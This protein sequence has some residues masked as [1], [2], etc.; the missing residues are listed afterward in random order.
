MSGGPNT[1]TPIEVLREADPGF[2]AFK[3]RYQ[4]HS[5]KNRRWADIADAAVRGFLGTLS[6]YNSKDAK[7]TTT[8]GSSRQKIGYRWYSWQPSP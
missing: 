5:A 8:M 6:S 2:R 7:L 4:A 1:T 3:V